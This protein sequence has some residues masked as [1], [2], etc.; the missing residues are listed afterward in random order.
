M[1]EMIY[2]PDQWENIRTS[3]ANVTITLSKIKG[4]HLIWGGILECAKMYVKPHHRIPSDPNTS[5]HLFC[6]FIG[7]DDNTYAHSLAAIK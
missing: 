3:F 2:E 6:H 1:R 7:F 5:F 4:H